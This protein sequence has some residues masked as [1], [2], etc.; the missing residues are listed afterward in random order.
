M[1][2]AAIRKLI[3]DSIAAAL[4]TQTKTMAEANNSIR[5]IPVAKRG[6]YKEFIRCQP[7]YFNGMEGV[8]GLI[9][10]FE[11]TE[12]IFSRSNC[13]EENKLAFATGTLTDDALSWWNDYAQTIGI[14]QANK[15]TRTEL[16]RL[17][18]NKYCPR[19]KIK[20]MKD[21]FYNL[22]VK[23]NDL[24]TYV[25]RF[26]KLVI[27]CPNM[28]QNNE[29]LMEVFIDGLLR[30]IEGNVAA[31]KPQTLEDAINI[32]QRTSVVIARM[33]FVNNKIE[34]QKLSDA[35]LL[36]QLRTIDILE[37][38]HCVRDVPYITQVLAQS[39]VESV[40]SFDVVIGMDW[41]S[42]CHAKI[43]CDEKVVHI[44]IEDET[45]IIQAQTE[46]LKEENVQAKNLQGM[47][48]AFEIRADG[49]RCIKN[50]SVIRFGKRG[51]LNPRYIG[52]FKIL[53]RI[54]P[55]AYK[56]E[57]P[58]ELSNVHNTF[59]ISNLNKCLSEKSLIIPMKEL[60]LDDKLNFVEVASKNL[61]DRV[62]SSKRRIFYYDVLD[63]PRFLV[64]ITETS[65]SR[66]HGKSESDSYYLSD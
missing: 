37:T 47:E 51:K 25:R 32:A 33:I 29:K 43:I 4:E 34:G 42:K 8:V 30:S 55:V 46:A 15:I 58:E 3:A 41:L 57:L 56:L 64:L 38:I 49:T 5:E 65:Q 21:E 18:I 60:K 35:M 39:G 48:K 24:K 52:P 2:Q 10:W 31:S 1:S 53:K 26:K 13:A 20:K 59:Y 17:L 66:Q 16:K 50:R 45:L 7:F 28:V 12:S 40:T 9:H 36:L 22:S 63:S 54:G 23:G 19:T 44:P 11:R 27:L 6:D 61:L 62:S 14:E